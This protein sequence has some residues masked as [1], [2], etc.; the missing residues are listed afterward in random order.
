MQKQLTTV[1]APSDIIR[2]LDVL[3]T[4]NGMTR[5][6]TIADAIRF[7]IATHPKARAIKAMLTNKKPARKSA[8]VVE[9]TE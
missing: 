2:E 1:A 6:D 8:R 4:A 3:A 9:K 7:R 5:G